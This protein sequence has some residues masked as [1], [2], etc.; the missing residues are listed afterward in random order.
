MLYR[1]VNPER[2]A[3]L[4]IGL[5]VA[6]QLPLTTITRRNSIQLRINMDSTDVGSSVPGS[7]SDVAPQEI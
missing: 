1:L 7:I 5:K 3:R 4:A 6:L 2:A